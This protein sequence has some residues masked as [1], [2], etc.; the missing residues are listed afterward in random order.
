[1]L[2]LGSIQ[3]PTSAVTKTFAI[4]AKK[5]AGKSYTAGVMMEEMFLNNLPFVVFDPIDVHW[6]LRFDKTGK[7]PMLPVVVFGVLENADIELTD[8]MGAVIAQA[9]VEKNISC[10]I[11]TF[12]MSKKGQRKL[13]TEFS[14]EL[15][16]INKTPR[17]IFIEEAHEFV[18]QRVGMDMGRVFSAVEALVVMGRNRGLGVTLINQRAATINKDVLTQIDTLLAFRNTSPHDRKALQEWV[19]AHGTEEDFNA[20]MASLPSLETGSGWIWS[21]EWLNKFERIKIRERDTLHPDRE[22]LD[23]E[24]EMPELKQEDVQDFITAFKSALVVEEE[25]PKR[26]NKTTKFPNGSE[27]TFGVD[28]GLGQD[29]SVEVLY[30]ETITPAHVHVDPKDT[31][32]EELEAEIVRLNGI[33]SNASKVLRGEPIP[34]TLIEQSKTTHVLEMWLDKIG[35]SNSAG[36]ILTLLKEKN[37]LKLTRHQIRT[38]VGISARSSGFASAVSLLK[39]NDLVR[40]IDGHLVINPELI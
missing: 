28:V 14:E 5:G 24:F 30:P 1:M 26:K 11:S 2:N 38:L 23:K 15:L 13:I 9:V 32:I 40:E 22:K 6:G 3:L 7:K 21:P 18:P 35:R 39:R 34:K 19:E 29:K 8:E 33:I 20:F 17:H 37:G 12:G 31:K 27:I 36:K 10:V 25:K 16:R 4:L